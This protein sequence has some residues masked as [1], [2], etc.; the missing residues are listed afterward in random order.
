MSQIYRILP[1]SKIK[2]VKLL[3]TPSSFIKRTLTFETNHEIKGTA[4]DRMKNVFGGRIEGSGRLATSRQTTAESTVLAGVTV[5]KKPIE[6][7]NCCMSGCVNCVW[8]Q[9]NDDLKDWKLTRKEAVKKIKETNEIW[10]SEFSPPVGLL[11]LK[12]LP[13]ELHQRKLELNKAPKI[14]TA[15]YFPTKGA[16]GAQNIPVK[17]KAF[18]KAQQVAAEDQME[19]EH[20]GWG[21][22]PVSFKVF[23][24]TEKLIKS[25]A[26][27]SAV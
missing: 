6:P 19:D 11:P 20:D 13:Q 22:V 8:E 23:A 10:P 16:P 14:T 25:K 7:D 3:R 12:N 15:S 27:K 26:K 2:P 4:E 17:S 5:C 9:Y 1:H 18:I 24:E 21:D